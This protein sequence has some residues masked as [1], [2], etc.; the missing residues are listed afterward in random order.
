MAHGKQFSGWV[1]EEAS[2]LTLKQTHAIINAG[3]T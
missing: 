1:Q 3:N 2:S